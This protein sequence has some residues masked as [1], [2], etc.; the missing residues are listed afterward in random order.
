MEESV[1]NWVFE[2]ECVRSF[3]Q[4]IR[5]EFTQKIEKIENELL[6]LAELL[7]QN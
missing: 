7:S 4:Q 3:N 1:L 2:P 6:E 5:D